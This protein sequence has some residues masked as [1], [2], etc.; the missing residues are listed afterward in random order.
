MSQPALLRDA[1]LLA[2]KG[3]SKDFLSWEQSRATIILGSDMG[4]YNATADW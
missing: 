2:L 1:T 3:K 4:E